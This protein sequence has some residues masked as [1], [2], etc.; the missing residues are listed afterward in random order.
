MHKK[1][2]K[3]VGNVISYLEKKYKQRL[4]KHQE[5]INLLKRK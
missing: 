2:R 1:A 4:N 3:L 5:I